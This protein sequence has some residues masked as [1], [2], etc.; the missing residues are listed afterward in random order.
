MAGLQSV[1]AFTAV[2]FL[3]WLGSHLYP[4]ACPRAPTYSCDAVVNDGKTQ[5]QKVQSQPTRAP[6]GRG[7]QTNS[8]SL[9]VPLCDQ[10]HCTAIIDLPPDY[11]ILVSFVRDFSGNQLQSVHDDAFKGLLSI[12]SL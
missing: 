8:V 5:G 2:F 9:Y 11:G 10:Q 1:S 12:T 7:K 6:F 3:P 4:L